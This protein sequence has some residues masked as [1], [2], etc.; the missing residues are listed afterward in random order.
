M[1]YRFCFLFLFFTFTI[2]TN[3]FNT[4]VFMIRKGKK[5][6]NKPCPNAPPPRLLRFSVF[7][8][9]PTIPTPPAISF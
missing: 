1:V 2:Y 9:P 6:A 5:K 8:N 4:V 7:S 3:S